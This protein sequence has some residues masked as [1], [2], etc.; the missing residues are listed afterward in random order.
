MNAESTASLSVVL[1]PNLVFSAESSTPRV[2]IVHS[3]PS[4]IEPIEASDKSQLDSL[5]PAQNRELD[6]ILML[7]FNPLGVSMITSRDKDFLWEL[8]YSILNRAELLP[9]FIM[10][11][12]WQDSERVQQLYDLLDL[13]K[14]PS[15]IQSLQLLDRRFMDPKVRAYAVHCLEVLSDDELSLYMLQLCQQLKFENYV[16]SALS[17]FLLR[18][19]L[20]NQKLIGSHININ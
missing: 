20:T 7:S 11:I 19:A 13:W 5:S 16:D 8:R 6:R 17:R 18:R 9:A 15:A 10:S 12:R 1:S 4:R 14:Q 2:R 3:M